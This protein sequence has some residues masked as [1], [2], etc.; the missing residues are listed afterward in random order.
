MPLNL[1]RC[2]MATSLGVILNYV[3][4]L[5]P[6]VIF[7]NAVTAGGSAKFLPVHNVHFVKY[8]GP[9]VKS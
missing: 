4:N 5:V 9:V 6:E 7:F 3:W 2:K 8:D 1:V